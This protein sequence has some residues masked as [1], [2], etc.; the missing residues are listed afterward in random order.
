VSD[1][2]VGTTTTYAT[3][4]STLPATIAFVPGNREPSTV[5]YSAA[6]SLPITNIQIDGLN[7]YWLERQ[8][9]GDLSSATTV[10]RTAAIGAT[11]AA[12]D[13]VS[14]PGW[15][16]P[17]VSMSVNSGNL[18]FITLNNAEV[19]GQPVSTYQVYLVSGGES[20]VLV[21]SSPATGPSFG[22]PLAVAGNVAY[23][24]LGAG[25]RQLVL[26]GSNTVSAV[27]PSPSQGWV[28]GVAANFMGTIFF[29]T[30]SSVYRL[31][32]P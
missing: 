1:F 4:G 29:E 28:N 25:V 26:D 19:A 18:V 12:S 9:P 30:D 10:I 2:A 6:L 14:F 13:V 16:N 20:P 23:Y 5:V 24:D 7:V 8:V 15:T 11:L 31:V 32:N 21:D 22:V 27:A 3:T 17:V